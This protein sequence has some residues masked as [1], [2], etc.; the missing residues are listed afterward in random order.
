MAM[1]D[2]EDSGMGEEMMDSKHRHLS[3]LRATL[4]GKHA[5]KELMSILVEVGMEVF[6]DVITTSEEWGIDGDVP[7]LHRI[8]VER[9]LEGRHPPGLQGVLQAVA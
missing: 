4:S 1:S 9:G 3:E 8:G 6:H 2:G 7:R 5:G